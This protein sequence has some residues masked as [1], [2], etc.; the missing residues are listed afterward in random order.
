MSVEPRISVICS[1]YNPG[2]YLTAA[3]ESIRSQTEMAWELIVVDDGSS[4]GTRD[5]LAAWPRRDPRIQVLFNEE[6]RGVGWSLNRAAECARGE[7]IAR[8]D[9]DDISLPER[10]SQQRLAAE[11]NPSASAV[12][13]YIDWIDERGKVHPGARGVGMD[14]DLLPWFSMFYNRIAGGGQLFCRREIFQA[15]GGFGRTSEY[16]ED[17]E[18][19]LALLSRGPVTVVPRPLYQ[20]RSSPDSFTKR[21]Q[22]RFRYSDRSLDAGIR[23]I[24]S[25]C[26]AH[27]TRAEAVMLRDF[28]VRYDD[29]TQNWNAVQERLGELAAKFK[30]PHGRS[31]APQRIQ[32]SIAAGWLNQALRA[33]NRRDGKKVWAHFRRSQQMAKGA[34]LATAAVWMTRLTCVGGRADRLI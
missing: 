34:W 22:R 10:L 25:A 20:W 29:G 27:I 7:W 19:W 28:W 13:C 6:N 23:A 21:T 31:V 26:G 16:G 30:D 5:E 12:A 3:L 1:A 2:P 14:T 11:K 24:E 33:L 4:D 15:L 17:R 32:N 9:A 8:M 18:L